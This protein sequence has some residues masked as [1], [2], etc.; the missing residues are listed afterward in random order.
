MDAQY[1]SASHDVTRA[2]YAEYTPDGLEFAFHLSQ[3]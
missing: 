2:T 1:V 3:P